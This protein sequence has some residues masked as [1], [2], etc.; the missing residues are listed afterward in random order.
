[1]R[2][3][4]FVSRQYAVVH[5]GEFEDITIAE[6]VEIRRSGE[7]WEDQGRIVTCRMCVGPTGCARFGPFPLFGL[8]TNEWDSGKHD[9]C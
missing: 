4:M 8:Y 5:I 1:M 2:V 6:W 7:S 3:S 9:F